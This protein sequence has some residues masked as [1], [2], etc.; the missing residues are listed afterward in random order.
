MQ[1]NIPSLETKTPPPVSEGPRRLQEVPRS[2][3]RLY[4]S[5]RSLR[6]FLPLTGPLVRG[7]APSAALSSSAPTP[8]RQLPEKTAPAKNSLLLVSM[9]NRAHLHRSGSGSAAGVSSESSVSQADTRRHAATVRS[10]HA[11]LAQD[12]GSQDFSSPLPDPRRSGHFN[13]KRP[14]S[15]GRSGGRRLRAPARSHLATRTCD[16]G[17]VLLRPQSVRTSCVRTHVG[18]K[19]F[20]RRCEN[21]AQERTAC[22]RLMS[23][24]STGSLE[25]FPANFNK[26]DI[27]L[28]C[29]GRAADRVPAEREVKQEKGREISRRLALVT[30]P[31]LFLRFGSRPWEQSS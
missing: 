1:N 7:E 2:L 21:G 3:S 17:L 25:S 30:R 11:E 20:I 8:S 22:Q 29:F 19:L 15:N 24:S 10:G 6:S 9:Y 5:T 26:S 4:I 28:R 12:R 13:H 14:P 16:I 18:G 31:F 23:P 27:C